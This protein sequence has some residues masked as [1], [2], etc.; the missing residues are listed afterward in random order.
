M[1]SNKAQQN[2]SRF[3]Y[4]YKEDNTIAEESK[5]ICAKA[6]KTVQSGSHYQSKFSGTNWN[7][8][9]KYAEPLTKAVN[10]DWRLVP[11]SN[12]TFEREVHE[13]SEDTMTYDNYNIP[14]KSMVKP[15]EKTESLNQSNA[16]L[17]SQMK[18]VIERMNSFLDR[19]GQKDSLNEIVKDDDWKTEKDLEQ[20]IKQLDQR[21]SQFN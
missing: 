7:P 10:L 18:W 20:K 15:T 1:C 3:D 19:M 11:N 13:D 9:D 12:L 5:S 16:L 17:E 8:T 2:C 4:Q 6:I 14:S 21:I